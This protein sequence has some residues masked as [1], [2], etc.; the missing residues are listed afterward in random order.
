[1]VKEIP[2]YRLQPGDNLHIK[3]LSAEEDASK[4][5]SDFAQGSNTY[6]DAG[7]YLS[8]FYISDSGI[9]RLPFIGNIAAGGKTIEEVRDLIQEEID[10]YMTGTAVNVRLVNF[11]VTV[12]GE[13]QRPGQYKIYQDMVNIY[14]MIGM[15][16]DM[17]SVA[18]RDEVLLI[19]KTQNGSSIHKINMLDVRL[20]ES[21]YFY[22]RPNDIIYVK[23]VK[24]KNFAFGTFPYAVFFGTVTSLLLILTFFK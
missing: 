14:E 5:L 18:L 24:A 17:T 13:V 6:Y 10:M 1:M 8:S 9:V 11:I 4:L 12:L 22:L 3:I 15:A 7:V 21:D 2:E 20:L 23:P 19:R 16:G